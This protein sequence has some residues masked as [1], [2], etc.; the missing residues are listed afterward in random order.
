MFNTSAEYTKERRRSGFEEYF[1]LL[2]RLP[3][4]KPFLATFLLKT[5]NDAAAGAASSREEDSV[6]Y[7]KNEEEIEEDRLLPF[8]LKRP[9]TAVHWF[10]YF[11]VPVACAAFVYAQLLTLLGGIRK[12]DWNNGSVWLAVF[13]CPLVLTIAL[14]FI[15]PIAVRV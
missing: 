10:G 1:E 2:L 11:Y 9:S 7:A 5:D 12:G 4:Y 8:D 15:A 13:T 3:E 6:H 14:A